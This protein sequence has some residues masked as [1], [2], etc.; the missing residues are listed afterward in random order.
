MV[1]RG[2][3]NQVSLRVHRTCGTS[4]TLACLSRQARQE[5]SRKGNAEPMTAAATL[6]VARLQVGTVLLSVCNSKSPV[7]GLFFSR[8]LP[9]RFMSSRVEGCGRRVR[10]CGRSRGRLRFRSLGMLASAVTANRPACVVGWAGAISAAARTAAAN[11]A[12]I[13]RAQALGCKVDRLC[14]MDKLRRAFLV[15]A[16]RTMHHAASSPPSAVAAATPVEP[17]AVATGPRPDTGRRQRS[18]LNACGRT[19]GQQ[20]RRSCQRHLWLWS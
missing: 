15:V 5:S 2:S 4:R 12:H 10:R 8:V 7:S 20:C 16:G 14:G 1:C 11:Q 19:R 18:S 17:L 3:S 9:G 6:E 13:R